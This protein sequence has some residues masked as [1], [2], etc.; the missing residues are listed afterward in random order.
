MG[1]APR[2]EQFALFASTKITGT[3]IGGG[4]VHGLPVAAFHHFG[5]A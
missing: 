3:G 2:P 5:I 4:A 1:V